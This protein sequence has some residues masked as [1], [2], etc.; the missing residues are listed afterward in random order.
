MGHARAF[1]IEKLVYKL[2]YRLLMPLE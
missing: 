2:P 1:P